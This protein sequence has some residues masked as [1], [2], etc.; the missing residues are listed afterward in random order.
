MRVIGKLA[1]FSL[2]FS[3]P[4]IAWANFGLGLD[5]ALLAMGWIAYAVGI[6]EYYVADRHVRAGHARGAPGEGE[7]GS[8]DVLTA[9]RAARREGTKRT[10]AMMSAE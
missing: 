9:G 4:A 10:P 1:T 5:A 8:G 3:V 2:M 6:V 7:G